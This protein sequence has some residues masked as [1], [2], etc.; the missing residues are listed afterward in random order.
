MS[1]NHSH[2]HRFL[3]NANVTHGYPKSAQGLQDLLALASTSTLPFLAIGEYIHQTQDCLAWMHWPS[4]CSALRWS[5]STLKSGDPT[6]NYLGFTKSTDIAPP[7]HRGY[8]AMQPP[9]V[10]QEHCP[11]CSTGAHPRRRHQTQPHMVC[12]LFVYMPASPELHRGFTILVTAETVG[13]QLPS[14]QQSL[15]GAFWLPGNP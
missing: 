13:S 1:P 5:Q 4:W 3:E 10:V 8:R 9:Q 11:N 12:I 6:R 15:S 7:K 2:R 14:E